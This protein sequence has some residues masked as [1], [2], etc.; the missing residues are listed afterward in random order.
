MFEDVANLISVYTV[1]TFDIYIGI[2]MHIYVMYLIRKPLR[3]LRRLKKT[4]H[5]NLTK[6]S[7]AISVTKHYTQYRAKY[8]LFVILALELFHF[9]CVF[10]VELHLANNIS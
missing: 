3:L 9:N 5:I 2:Q 7:L 6:F 8:I 4:F 10:C 1:L